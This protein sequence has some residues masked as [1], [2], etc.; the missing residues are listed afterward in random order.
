[1]PFAGNTTYVGYPVFDHCF[2]SSTA[3]VAAVVD[4]SYRI[5][6][7]RPDTV[8]KVQKVRSAIFDLSCLA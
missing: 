8:Y 6:S 5:I 3:D 4:Y 2:A 1:M 7:V